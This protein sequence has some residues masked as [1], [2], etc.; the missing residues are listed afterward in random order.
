MNGFEFINEFNQHQEWK[1]IP[2]ILLTAANLSSEQKTLLHNSVDSIIEKY[3]YAG[4][5]FCEQAD[6]YVKSY[7]T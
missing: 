4:S 6:Q 7:I 5:E 2:D 3:E 1:D